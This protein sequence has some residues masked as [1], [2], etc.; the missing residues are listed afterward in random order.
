VN[1]PY[2]IISY[3]FPSISVIS[4]HYPLSVS[5][6]FLLFIHRGSAPLF[7]ASL[8]ARALPPHTTLVPHDSTRAASL[9]VS[10]HR[11]SIPYPDALSSRTYIPVA[12]LSPFPCLISLCYTGTSS[13]SS[14]YLY[15]SLSDLVL[16]SPSAPSVCVSSLL[17]AVRHIRSDHLTVPT[18]PYRR[19]YAPPPPFRPRSPQTTPSPLPS[20]PTTPCQPPAN[21]TYTASNSPS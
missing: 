5:L 1:P 10:L 13:L 18:T 15:C 9:I 3:L 6:L 21:R 11:Y 16:Y 7:A 4:F 8:T 12:T 14:L 19:P 2:A 17:S 20:T